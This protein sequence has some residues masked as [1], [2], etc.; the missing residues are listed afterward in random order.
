LNNVL[1]VNLL[2]FCDARGKAS[3]VVH[4]PD[5]TEKVARTEDVDWRVGKLLRD[6]ILC[7]LGYYHLTRDDEA[8]R[9]DWVTLEEEHSAFWEALEFD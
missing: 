7:Q 3:I 9:E 1:I 8:H 4:Q 5:V 2:T 6:P